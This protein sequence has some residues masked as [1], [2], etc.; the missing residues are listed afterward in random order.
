MSTT[1]NSKKEKKTEADMIIE[2]PNEELWSLVTDKKKKSK[3]KVQWATD[4]MLSEP[5]PI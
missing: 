5:L 3:L 1:E 4:S 2:I